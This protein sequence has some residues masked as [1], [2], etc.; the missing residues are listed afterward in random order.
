MTNVWQKADKL[1][2]EF[3][4]C[5]KE[6]MIQRFKQKGRFW[7]Y[8]EKRDWSSNKPFHLLRNYYRSVARQFLNKPYSSFCFKIRN[9]EV[10]ASS[11]FNRHHLEEWLTDLNIG[12]HSYY[13]LEKVYLDENYILRGEVPCKLGRY[14]WET[15]A[16]KLYPNINCEFNRKG[17]PILF[18]DGIHYA[19]SLTYRVKKHHSTYIGHDPETLKVLW[20]TWITLEPVWQQLNTKRLRSLELTNNP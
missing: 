17:Y 7:D 18:K 9:S 19:K 10:Y 3:T 13:V 6:S 11:K 2:R 14:K 4:N 20:R 12:Y 16:S 5:T 8:V 1:E 15:P